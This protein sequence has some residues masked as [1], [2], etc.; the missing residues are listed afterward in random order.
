MTTEH[1]FTQVDVPR[2]E[3]VMT[4]K[5]RLIT[6]LLMIVPIVNIILMFV[7]AFGNDGTLN[8]KNWAKAQLIL[9]LVITILYFVIIALM[10]GLLAVGSSYQ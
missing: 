9:A 5:E 7:W 4:V 2:N 6:G 8:R 3:K 10:F 1:V